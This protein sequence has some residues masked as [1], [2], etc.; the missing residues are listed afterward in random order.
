MGLEVTAYRKLK[1]LDVLFNEDG[2]AVD[3]TTREPV[4]DYLRVYD[5][6]D[7]PG[8]AAGL[9]DRA[10]YAYEDAEGFWSGGYGRYNNWREELAKLAGYPPSERVMYGHSE[11]LHAASAWNGVVT[12]GPFYELV[13]YADNEGTIGPVVSAKL[14]RD[15]SEWADRAA[16]I[17]GN[18]Y[19]KFMEWRR[20]FEFAADDGAV[21]FH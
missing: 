5:N 8:R 9:E 20:C 4:E 21:S 15:F 6:P 11:N 2:E 19:E 10:A 12:E 13:N 14:A 17:G 18:F 3:P 7:F 1:K 16:A